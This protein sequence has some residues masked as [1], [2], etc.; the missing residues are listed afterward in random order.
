MTS[1]I[2]LLMSSELSLVM[3]LL[4]SSSEADTSSTESSSAIIKWNPVMVSIQNVMFNCLVDT[5]IIVALT[6]HQL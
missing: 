3:S 6:E 5:S 1:L 4:T 2:P